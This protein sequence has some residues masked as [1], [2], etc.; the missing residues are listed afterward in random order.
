MAGLRLLF[1]GHYDR[2]K[3]QGGQRAAPVKEKPVRRMCGQKQIRNVELGNG[4]N[5]LCSN[6]PGRSVTASTL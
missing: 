1:T 6:C 2:L 4:R 5:F 3:K